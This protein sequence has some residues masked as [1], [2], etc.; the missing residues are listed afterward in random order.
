[1]KVQLLRRKTVVYPEEVNGVQPPLNL[2]H[3]FQ[4]VF[5]QNTVQT[6]LLVIKSYICTGKPLKIVHNVIFTSATGGLWVPYRGFTPGPHW[7]TSICP[8]DHLAWPPFKNFPILPCEPPVKSWVRLWRETP[9]F[10]RYVDQVC[11]YCM[12]T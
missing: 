5:E 1:M 9:N 4:F 7:W 6:L 12:D 8:T 11:A 10:I 3:F 2:Q